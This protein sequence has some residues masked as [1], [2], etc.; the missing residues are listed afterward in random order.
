MGQTSSPRRRRRRKTLSASDKPVI[1]VY[2]YLSP[3]SIDQDL[4]PL[5]EE[6][7]KELGIHLEVAYFPSRHAVYRFPSA[8]LK[9]LDPYPFV[10]PTNGE[11]RTLSG[12]I[13]ELND[14]FERGIVVNY[15]LSMPGLLVSDWIDTSVPKNERKLQSIAKKDTQNGTKRTRKRY[16]RNQ[17]VGSCEQ[18]PTV[19]TPTR[20]RRRRST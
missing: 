12:H 3:V 4:C 14:K 1:G 19:S 17:N 2:A 10:L 16:S 5:V 9:K 6:R 7:M 18:V 11:K 15:E 13:L 8:D 20:R